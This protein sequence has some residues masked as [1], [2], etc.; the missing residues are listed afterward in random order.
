MKCERLFNFLLLDLDEWKT[1]IRTNGG[2]VQDY[3]ISYQN[4]DTTTTYY[5][6]VIAYN[7]FGISVPC[8]SEET[9]SNFTTLILC[10]KHAQFCQNDFVICWRKSWRLIFFMALI[11]KSNVLCQIWSNNPL[12]GGTTCCVYSHLA[13]QGGSWNYS[14]QVTNDQPEKTPTPTSSSF[15][16]Y[17]LGWNAFQSLFGIRLFVASEAVLPRGLVRGGAGCSIDCDH[18]Y[19][20]GHS[21]CQVEN[22]QVQR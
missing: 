13:S 11:F 16:L 17:F 9:V 20:C 8:T 6:R 4:L 1:E 15:N 5:F 3:T 12:P 2:A 22:L 7:E 19:G 21:L 10:S 18:H 14:P